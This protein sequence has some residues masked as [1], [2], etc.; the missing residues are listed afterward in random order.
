MLATTRS[1]EFELIAENAV[2]SRLLIAPEARNYGHEAP[3]NEL[4]Y[5]RVRV[6]LGER[7]TARNVRSMFESQG[8]PFPPELSVYRGYEIYLIGLAV[9]IIKEGGWQAVKR[10]GLRVELP[11]SPRFIVIGLAPETRLVSRGSLGFQCNANVGLNGGIELPAS[12]LS[13]VSFPPVAANAEAR[14][15]VAAHVAMNLSFSVMS[16]ATVAVGKGDRRAEWV[17]DAADEP[18]LGDQELFFTVL[19]PPIADE[20]ELSA[21]ILATISSFDLIPCLL[22]S[23]EV[24]LNVPLQ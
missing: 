1:L 2:D 3:S 23:A 17:I 15:T 5:K 21:S 24:K 9:G 8:K 22:R 4:T 11:D 13:S 7:P 12:A 10:L 14:A 16:P 20:I 18:L 19:A 6:R